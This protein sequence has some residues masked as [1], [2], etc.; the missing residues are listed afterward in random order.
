M[1][2]QEPVS[3]AAPAPAKKPNVI[4]RLYLWVLSWAET[5]YG[6]PA[7]FVISF[8]ESSF[9]PIPP[10]VL[11]IAL[12]V[13][14]PKRAFFYATVSVIAS[15]LGGVF[16]WYIGSALWGSISG[17]FFEYVPGFTP[18]RFEMVR[19]KYDEHAFL[20]IFGAAFTPI[21]YK[22]FTIAAGA[23]AVSIQTLIFASI[24]GR[25]ARFYL[26]ASAIFF[27]GPKV[28]EWLEKYF[29]LATILLVAL[30]AAGFL[31]VKYLL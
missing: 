9:F 18:E 21:P 8:V 28:K 12:S 19:A 10:D 22:V 27:F 20:A 16:G 1:A 26:V 30:G 15:V 31:A 7:L 25:G 2:A 13:A 5:P 23:C 24:V 3:A 6:T 29:E 14:R 4:K 11:Q 17:F